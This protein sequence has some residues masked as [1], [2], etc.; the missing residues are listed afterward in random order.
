MCF[1]ICSAKNFASVTTS[2]TDSTSPKIIKLKLSLAA[3]TTAITLS[4]LKVISAKRTL[5]TL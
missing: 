3:P 1:L 2:S 5:Y 4:K